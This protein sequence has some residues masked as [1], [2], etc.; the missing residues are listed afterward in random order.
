MPAFWRF[1]SRRRQSGVFHRELPDQ[2]VAAGGAVAGSGLGHCA[3][4]ERYDP[5]PPERLEETEEELSTLMA[6]I[7]FMSYMH[8]KGIDRALEKSRFATTKEEGDMSIFFRFRN[9]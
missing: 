3:Q 2:P 4:W 1:L 5:E 6:Q 7:R 9:T 8:Q